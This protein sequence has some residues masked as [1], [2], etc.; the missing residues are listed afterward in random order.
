MFQATQVNPGPYRSYRPRGLGHFD[1]STDVHSVTRPGT[2]HS[3][4]TFQPQAPASEASEQLSQLSQVLRPIIILSLNVPYFFLF[5]S[6]AQ[7]PALQFP[8][9][10]RPLKIYTGEQLSSGLG[11]PEASSVASVFDCHHGCF[12]PDPSEVSLTSN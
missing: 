3:L 12:T 1:P 10:P 11:D 2:G 4:L 5:Q 7:V 9:R 6:S 8:S